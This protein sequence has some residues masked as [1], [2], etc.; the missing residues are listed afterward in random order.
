MTTALASRMTTQTTK[1]TRTNRAK[2]RDP[3]VTQIQTQIKMKTIQ[4]GRR[5]TTTLIKIK[6]QMLN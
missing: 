2:G 3:N 1:T 5:M 4:R 6:S